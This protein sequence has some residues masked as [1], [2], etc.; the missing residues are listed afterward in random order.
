MENQSRLPPE[1]S[2]T[3]KI[4]P[5]SSIQIYMT[6]TDYIEGLLSYFKAKDANR[7]EYIINIINTFPKATGQSILIALSVRSAWVTYLQVLASLGKK[8][9]TWLANSDDWPQYS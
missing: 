3:K 2:V 5:L 1:F 4:E 8:F 6:A 7:G 9:P